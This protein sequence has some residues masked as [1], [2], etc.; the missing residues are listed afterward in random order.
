MEGKTILVAIDFQEASLEAL[1]LARELAPR[2]GLEVTALHVYRIPIVAYPGGGPVPTPAFSEAIAA[3]AKQ[4]MDQLATSSE[5]ITP[6]IRSGDP[7]DEI[8]AVI[9][10]LRPAMVVL[11]T[12]G[13]TGAMRLFIG[14]VAERVVRASPMPVLTVHAKSVDAPAASA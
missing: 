4:A 3:A 10:E 2:L 13:R 12:H 7:V 11:G 9:D 6:L 1:A 8:L 14:S 5:G